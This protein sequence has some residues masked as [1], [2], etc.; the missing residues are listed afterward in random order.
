MKIEILGDN[1]E[2]ARRSIVPNISVWGAAQSALVHMGRPCEDILWPSAQ[3]RRKVFIEEQ[4]HQQRRQSF[5]RARLQTP[6]MPGYLL[7]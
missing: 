4:L 1:Y 2:V 7:L 5:A 6:G 3:P